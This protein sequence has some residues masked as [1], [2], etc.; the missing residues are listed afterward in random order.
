M[1][2]S[3]NPSQC[4]HY[5]YYHNHSQWN[6]INTARWVGKNHRE[7]RIHSLAF[8]LGSFINL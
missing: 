1:A 4:R 5:F 3:F 6:S 8:E 7:Q 2:V